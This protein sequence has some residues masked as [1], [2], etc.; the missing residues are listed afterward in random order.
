MSESDKKNEPEEF[1]RINMEVVEFYPFDPITNPKKF[2]G[3]LHVYLIDLEMDIR[4]I[5]VVKQGKGIFI[6]LPRKMYID[7]DTDE[8]KTYPIV[9]FSDSKKTRALYLSIKELGK[10][11][12]EQYL[13]EKL[14]SPIES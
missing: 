11:Y 12:I 9:S 13:K 4:G 10:K 7:E 6:D 8:R 1:E 3:T 2:K 5:V 14:G